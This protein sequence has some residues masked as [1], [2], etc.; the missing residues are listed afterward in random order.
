MVVG[1]LIGA[2][3]LAKLTAGFTVALPTAALWA[4][5][6]WQANKQRH[7]SA[8]SPAEVGRD[9]PPPP[10]PH[11]GSLPHPAGRRH[12]SLTWRGGAVMVLTA[13]AVLLP[14]LA[15]NASWTG[16]PVFPFATSV[17]GAGHWAE[18]ADGSD[19]RESETSALESETPGRPA[20]T[21]RVARWEAAHRS[22][23]G[24]GER[25]QAVWRQALGNRGYGAYGGSPTPTETQNIARFSTEGGLP[26]LWLAGLAG[27][28]YGL[29]RPRWRGPAAAGVVVLAAQGLWW[30]TM[31]HLQSR[32]LVV[33]VLPLAWGVGL[34][35]IGVAGPVHGESGTSVG[36]PRH[37]AAVFLAI[38][39]S[40]VLAVVS[41]TTLWEQT[42]RVT[43]PDGRQVPAPLWLV[44]DGLPAP[45]GRGVMASPAVNDLPPGSRVMVVGDNQSLFY[46]RPELVYASAFDRSP[47]T[48]I[49][50]DTREPAAVARRLRDAGVTHLWLGYSELDRLHATYG[51]DA[52]VTRA[53]LQRITRGWQTLTP[54]GGGSVLLAVPN[55]E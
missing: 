25:W 10:P 51:F 32:F 5:W 43:L 36:G 6:T 8:T 39:L 26:V 42:T 3:T 33:G 31:T 17:F 11:P 54:P 28:G 23:A 1:L 30:L 19:A 13:A 27:L 49:L 55:P 50:R 4:W 53:A 15:R 7:A 52:G 44:L 22:S 35:L 47:I 21:T 37:R 48:S 34:L 16:N 41:L 45:A 38:G 29:T 12:Q 14:Y 18:A 9:T 40:A 46:A 20:A 2:A 24:W